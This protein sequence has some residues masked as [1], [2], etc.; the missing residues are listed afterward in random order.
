MLLIITD[1]A[2]KFSG[3]TKIDDLEQLLISK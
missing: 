1:T 2:D 3:G